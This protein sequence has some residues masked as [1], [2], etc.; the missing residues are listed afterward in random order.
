[1]DGISGSTN[2]LIDLGM[3]MS[4]V[5]LKSAL[6]ISTFKKGLDVQSQNAMSLIESAVAASPRVNSSQTGQLIDIVA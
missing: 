5:R 3:A 4:D 2:S 6:S 1:M